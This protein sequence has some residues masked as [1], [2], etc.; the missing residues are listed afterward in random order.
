[1]S[2][3]DFEM[4]A[5]LIREERERFKSN[6]A[7]IAFAAAMARELSYTNSRFDR[8]RFIMAAMPRAW[9]GTRHSAA[10]EREASN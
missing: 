7:H 1:M 6:A 4:L 5:R 9:V 10:W 2:K 8:G 3:K